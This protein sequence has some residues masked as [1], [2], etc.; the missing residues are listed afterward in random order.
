MVFK[1]QSERLLFYLSDFFNHEL[2]RHI[3][4]NKS[5]T[6]GPRDKK[7]PAAAAITSQPH[8]NNLRIIYEQKGHDFL[9]YFC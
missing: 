9:C 1:S 3:I 8:V 5:L 6:H 7:K 2:F 4:K